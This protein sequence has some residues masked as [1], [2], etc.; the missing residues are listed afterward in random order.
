[1]NKVIFSFL[2]ATFIVQSQGSKFPDFVNIASGGE[3]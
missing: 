2:L 3:K 1:M